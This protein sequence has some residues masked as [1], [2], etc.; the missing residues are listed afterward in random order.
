MPLP[1]IDRTVDAVIDAI[2][3]SFTAYWTGLPSP[4]PIAWDNDHFDPND[5]AIGSGDAAAWI[6]FTV[7][8]TPGLSGPAGI[9]DGQNKLFRRQ[10]QIFVQ[11]F[12]KLGAGRV[13]SNILVERALLYFETVEPPQG[14]WY[15]QPSPF[16]VPAET[17]GWYQVNVS[18]DLVY[19]V[20][21]TTTP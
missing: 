13:R 11:V 6:R 17:S 15:R 12:T 19:D 21:R 9:E 7:Q 1:A 3:T 14:V 4:S 8:H 2:Q 20:L 5:A 16:E 10:G 18:A